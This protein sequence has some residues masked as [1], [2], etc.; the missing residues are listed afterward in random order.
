VEAA[1]LDVDPEETPCDGVP[2]WAL[3]EACVDRDQHVYAHPV[4]VAA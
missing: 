3:A 2:S 4:K 1:A